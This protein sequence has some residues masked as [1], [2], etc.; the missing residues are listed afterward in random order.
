MVDRVQFE[1]GQ[2]P[3]LSADQIDPSKM[4]AFLMRNGIAKNPRQASILLIAVII[5][6]CIGMTFFILSVTTEEKV[7]QVESLFEEESAL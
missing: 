7:T 4:V 5:I 3:S 6:C 1:E 2:Y